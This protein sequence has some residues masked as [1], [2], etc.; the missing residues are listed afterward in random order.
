MKKSKKSQLEALTKMPDD[1]IQ[2]DEDAPRTDASFW[3]NA[4]LSIPEKKSKQAKYGLK[5]DL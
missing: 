2:Y 4:T 1:T 3:D 5:D